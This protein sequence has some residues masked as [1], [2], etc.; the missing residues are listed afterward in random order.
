MNVRH[1]PLLGLL[2][3]LLVSCTHDIDHPVEAPTQDERQVLSQPSPS[4]QV[5]QEICSK[6]TARELRDEEPQMTHMGT[7]GAISLYGHRRALLCSEPGPGGVGECEI[8]ADK[9]IKV[10]TPSETYGLKPQIGRV[11]GLLVYGPDRVFC[12]ARR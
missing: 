6:I 1:L 8:V 12:K 9:S 5:E 7:I 4:S 11:P 3:T 2:S 10:V